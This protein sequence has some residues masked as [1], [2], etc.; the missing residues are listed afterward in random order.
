[1][2]DSSPKVSMYLDSIC[3]LSIDTL[4]DLPK[5]EVM[6]AQIALFFD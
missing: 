5:I 3:P 2:L 4:R 6:D 1:M